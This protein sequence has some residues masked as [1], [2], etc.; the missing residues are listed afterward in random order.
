MARRTRTTQR[1]GLDRILPR[2]DP[3]ARG[4]RG[5]PHA[6]RARGAAPTRPAAGDD[7]GAT[8]IPDW[9]DT[10]AG[11]R[12]WSG[13]RA[14]ERR[15]DDSG[16]RAETRAD[17][18]PRHV[19][20]RAGG[21]AREEASSDGGDWNDRDRNDRDGNEGAGDDSG[22]AGDDTGHWDEVLD[23]SGSPG[24]GEFADRG[25]EDAYAEPGTEPEDWDDG[26]WDEDEDWEDPP[27]R[28]LTMLPPAAIGLI[29]VGVIACVIAGFSLL[30]GTEP[31][32]PLVDFPASAGPSSQAAPG[33]PSAETPAEIVVSVAGLV[34]RPGL[35]R[36]PPNSRVAEA[37]D[38]AGG[39]RENADLLSL[40]LA[41]I[42]HDGDQVLVG[43]REGG[44][45]AVR[46]AVVSSAPGTAP[47]TSPGTVP[48]AAPQSGTV[49]LNTATEAELDTLPG[50]GPVTAKAII[51]WRE[52]NGGF[53][54]VDQLAEVE[55]IGPAR[56]AKL[57][58][59]VTVG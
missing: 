9:L 24:D 54:S 55:G 33:A 10:A 56:L 43:T 23:R 53:A 31:V 7:W 47:D 50:V 36:L 11:R 34:R 22:A 27:R 52:R 35:V 6:D 29:G 15:D 2:D 51:A 37:L 44:V 16:D 59:A 26:E 1:G 5:R 57:R 58:D 3:R 38:R 32:A 14:A 12:A 4:P 18:E 17:G 19:P 48:G 42:L 39:A 41:Q 20:R 8:R 28:R 21:V 40:N 25:H 49:N 13:D 46:S 45:G 30:R